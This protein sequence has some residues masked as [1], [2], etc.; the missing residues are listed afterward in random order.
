MK[1]KTRKK[2]DPHALW[3]SSAEEQLGEDVVAKLRDDWDAMDTRYG[4]KDY[5]KGNGIIRTLCDQGLTVLQIRG[6]LGQVGQKS[7]ETIRDHDPRAEPVERTRRRSHNAFSLEEI[8]LVEQFI[9][10]QE[11]EDGFPCSHRNPKQCLA[12]EAVTWKSLHI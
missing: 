6:A 2:S 5:E 7:I 8:D 10:N 4:G 12:G 1:K 3:R 9:R 11:I